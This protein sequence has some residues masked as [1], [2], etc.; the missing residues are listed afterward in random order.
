MVGWRKI[1]ANIQKFREQQNPTQND[2][3]E[4]I[5][6]QYHLVMLINRALNGQVIFVGAKPIQI[7]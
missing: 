2:K 4:F 7:E 1:E 3:I 5:T 6:H